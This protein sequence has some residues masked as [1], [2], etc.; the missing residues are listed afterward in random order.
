[1]GTRARA[2]PPLWFVPHL[3]TEVLL[4]FSA[5]LLLISLVFAFVSAPEYL[6]FHFTLGSFI[7]ERY[8]IS[9]NH[10]YDFIKG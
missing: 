2:R 6:V 4:L 5:L 8:R 1:M 3:R 7:V 10:D 9:C